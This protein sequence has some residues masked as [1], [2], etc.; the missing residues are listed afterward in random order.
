MKFKSFGLLALL[1]ILFCNVSIAL[2]Q[3]SYPPFV[4]TNCEGRF[5]ARNASSSL[6][7]MRVVYVG[8]LTPIYEGYVAGYGSFIAEIPQGRQ[9]YFVSGSLALLEQATWQSCMDPGALVYDGSIV[10]IPPVASYPTYTPVFSSVSCSDGSYE[11]F[12]PMPSVSAR[13]Y[14]PG[15]AVAVTLTDGPAGRTSVS[16]S[17]YVGVLNSGKVDV[18]GGCFSRSAV[19][20]WQDPITSTVYSIAGWYKV[21]VN[22]QKA[23]VFGLLSGKTRQVVVVWY[24]KNYL[25]PDLLTQAVIAY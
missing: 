18:L 24:D 16:Q 21:E 2:S 14:P 12:L 22:G 3:S 9:L 4:I 20:S 23:V 25:T 1:A 10:Y 13:Q 8:D 19:T 11:G 7:W 5:T 17:D 6:V 15:S